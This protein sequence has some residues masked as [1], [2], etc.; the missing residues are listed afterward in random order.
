MK[1]ASQ[2]FSK[3]K[4]SINECSLIAAAKYETLLKKQHSKVAKQAKLSKT[5]LL[6]LLMACFFTACEDVVEV[7]INTNDIDL[8]SVEAYINTRDSDN[9]FVKLE[10]S[11][12]VN[13]AEQN[14]AINKAT[15]EISDM[16]P[17]PNSILLEEDGQTGIY[18]I[19]ANK[20]YLAVPGRNYK[21]TIT[22]PD[23]VV[24]TAHDYLQKVE[25]LDSV[26]INLSALGDYEYLGIYINS[27]ETQGEGNYY[28][29][30]IYINNNLIN[31]SDE[32][33]FASDELV[34]GNY[35]YDLE[36]FID[37][38][39]EEKDRKLLAGDTIRVEQLSISETTYDF[40]LGM[41]NQAFSGSPFSVP[42][43]NLQNN[44]SGSDG[45][46][47]LGL[48]SARDIS[49]GNEVIIDDNNF[50]PHVSS[51][52]MSIK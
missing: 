33:T 19:P 16:Q 45:K 3:T 24:I 27:Q 7:D 8:I 15:I 18:K 34:E 22:T 10:K 37:W 35:I 47:V 6:I 23:G 49:V 36:I 40:Y 2:L 41:Q 14:P 11:L 46:P 4:I 30:D 43:A 13:K 32:L 50:S 17:V 12:P 28:K 44:L 20:N 42:P 26:K 9:I 29:W 48:F 21:L 31:E 39:D 25:P 38:F 5:Y 1:Q 51:V 52:S